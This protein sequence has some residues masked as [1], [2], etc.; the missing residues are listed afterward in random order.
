MSIPRKNRVMDA[1]LPPE[2]IRARMEIIHPYTKWIRS[3]SCT[4]G[5]EHTPAIAKSMGLD[6]FS[7]SAMDEKW[8]AGAEGGCGPHWGFWDTEGRPRYGWH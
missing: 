5:D 6:L 2:Q 8:K 7:F 1:P 3:F 4:G